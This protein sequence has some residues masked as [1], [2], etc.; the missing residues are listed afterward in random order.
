MVVRVPGTLVPGKLARRWFV[1]AA[2][3]AAPQFAAA[4]TGSLYT[5]TTLRAIMGRNSTARFNSQFFE[6]QAVSQAIPRYAFSE[7]NRNLA[8]LTMGS[9]VRQPQFKPFSS[10][11]RGP[12]VTPYLDLS[13]PYTSTANSFYTNVSPRLAEERAREVAMKQQMSRQRD[14]NSAAAKGPYDPQ[15]SDKMAP[16]GH[17]AVFMNYGGFFPQ[18]APRRR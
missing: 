8:N 5:D 14:L 17:S 18:S 3:A 6:N 4:Q 15:G 7:V 1:V 2:L 16:T 13:N 12:T 11:Q 10:V 9:V